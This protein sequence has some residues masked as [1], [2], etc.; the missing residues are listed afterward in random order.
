MCQDVLF[1]RGNSLGKYSHLCVENKQIRQ[2]WEHI[3]AHD[4][5][6]EDEKVD[7]LSKCGETYTFVKVETNKQK[8]NKI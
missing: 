7:Q 5:D 6:D 4:G 1:N 8:M 2:F 3:S